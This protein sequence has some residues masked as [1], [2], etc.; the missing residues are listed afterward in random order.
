VPGINILRAHVVTEALH[1]SGERFP[2]PACHPGTHIISKLGQKLVMKFGLQPY[3]L[4]A[5]RLGGSG[6]V[7]YCADIRR[8]LRERGQARCIFFLKHGHPKRGTGSGI[9]TTLAYQLAISIPEF[10]LP[11]QQAIEKDKLVA[12]RALTVQFQRLLVEPFQQVAPL[13]SPPVVVLDGLDEFDDHKVQEQI[14]RLFISA[15]RDYQLPLRILVT[16]RPEPHLREIFEMKEACATCRCSALSADCTDI[17]T[18]LRDEFSRIHSEN[19]ARGTDLGAVW[20][21]PDALLNL[22]S[23]SSGIFVYATTVVRY[24]DD[25]YWNPQ[26][27][28]LSV[29]ALDPESTAPLDDLYTSILSIV[30]H[31]PQNSRILHLIWCGGWNPEEVDIILKL[32][33]GTS[34]RILSSLC[35]LLDVPELSTRYSRR[36]A[37]GFLHASFHDFLHDERRSGR[38]CIAPSWL[39]SDWLASMIRLLS[40]PRRVD[41]NT[42]F[43]Q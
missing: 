23:K 40:I 6:K 16:S 22:V 43:Y 24:I 37:V 29:L 8:E 15:V 13:Q 25:R 5:S 26:E 27:R 21:P 9:I 2:E 36:S 30:P 11:L 4:V 28:L 20:P 18:Y 14:V 42:A 1:D 33:G 34:R 39:E 31:V 7:G 10:L 17:R 32:R 38:W 12:G 19:L 3:Y 35:S 41:Q